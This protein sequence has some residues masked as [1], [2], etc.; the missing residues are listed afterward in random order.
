MIARF[1]KVS[2]KTV[3]KMGYTI[4]PLEKQDNNITESL[5]EEA[6]ALQREVLNTTQLFTY[7]KSHNPST[8]A[9]RPELYCLL[10]EK[11]LRAEEALL[12]YDIL[13]KGLELLNET[14]M[15]R[16]IPILQESC[17]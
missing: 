4:H 13:S 6:R 10:G 3:L 5:E 11:T 2:S 1:Q 14:V 16:T 8:W 7:W 9:G 17:L 12:A 15:L